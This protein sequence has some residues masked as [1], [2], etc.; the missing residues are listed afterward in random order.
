LRRLILGKAKRGDREF[1]REKQLVQ[2]NRILKR[3]VAHLRKTLARVDL[4]QENV[5]EAI[6]KNY[7]E[8]HAQTGQ[9]II[10]K[11]K[12]EWKCRWE[13][14][15]GHLEIFPYNKMDSTWYYR[16]CS[17]APKCKNRT[18]AQK[19]DPSTVKGIVKKPTQ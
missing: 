12:R 8:E 9:D 17:N 18:L 15:D 11:L 14:C 3:Q 10:E 2:E 6:E 1:T 13:K 16:I 4:G 19:Y 5:K 7:T